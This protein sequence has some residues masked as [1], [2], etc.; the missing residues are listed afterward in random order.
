MYSFHHDVT[1][2]QKFCDQ[3]TQTKSNI[4]GSSSGR[5][6]IIPSGVPQIQE[7]KTNVI[8][9]YVGKFKQVGKFK[10]YKMI[11]AIFSG[12][13]HIQRM[14]MIDNKFGESMWDQ[15]VS[16]SHNCLRS[17]KELIN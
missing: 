3:K 16:R 10:L 8:C 2:S 12:G 1:K 15:S 9:E 4:T 17:F 6:N 5:R 11:V 7:R 13:S 14:K